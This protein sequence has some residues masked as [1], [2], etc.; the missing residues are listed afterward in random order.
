MATIKPVKAKKGKDD[1][2]YS[3]YFLKLLMFFVLGT[4]WIKWDGRVVFPVGL[5]LGIL[6]ATHEHFRIDRKVEYAILLVSAMFALY[7]PGIFLIL[8]QAN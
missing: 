7:G 8:H 6:F 2:G 4:I 3:V 5:I 1:E